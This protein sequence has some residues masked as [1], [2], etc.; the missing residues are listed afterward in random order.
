MAVP[1][2]AS[3]DVWKDH[4]SVFHRSMNDRLNDPAYSVVSAMVFWTDPV[5]VTALGQQFIGSPSYRIVN[6]LALQPWP[7]ELP[8]SVGHDALASEG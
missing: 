3:L 2:P 5:V 8:L 7:A 4:E 6:P 1:G